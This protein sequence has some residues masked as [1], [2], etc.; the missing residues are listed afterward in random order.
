MKEAGHDIHGCDLRG[1]LDCRETFR[2]NDVK[3]DLVVHCAD[4]GL[5]ARRLGT[6]ADLFEW[7]DRI[8]PT[9]V[10][11]L[12]SDA[13]YPASLQQEPYRLVEDDAAPD[14]P[15]GWVYAAS[16]QLALDLGCYVFR[17]FQVYGEGGTGV[18]HQ[19]AQMV[20]EEKALFRVPGCGRVMDFIHVDDAVATMVAALETTPTGPVNLCSGDPIAVDD[21]ALAMM[22]VVGWKPQQF[23]CDAS[24]ATFFRCGS[25]TLMDEVRPTA[26]S[27]VEGI[28]RYFQ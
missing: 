5:P 20:R 19:V 18:F 22:N 26:I 13:V 21:L 11:Y 6:D 8:K 25:T 3:Y 12:S 23:V 9:K 2:V 27:L 28:R 16:E 1:G 15:M 14:T 17:P 7:V 24:D 4:D 10:V